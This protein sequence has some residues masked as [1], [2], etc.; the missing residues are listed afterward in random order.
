MRYS[1]VNQLSFLPDRGRAVG[2]LD[3]QTSPHEE[4][5]QVKV[6]EEGRHEEARWMSL[7]AS[8][9]TSGKGFGHEDLSA[10][11]DP[12]CYNSM[13][14]SSHAAPRGHLSE[15]DDMDVYDQ[16]VDS[17]SLQAQN[18][19]RSNLRTFS[20][21]QRKNKVMVE[22]SGASSS[23]TPVFNP[24]VSGEVEVVGQN[25]NNRRFSDYAPKNEYENCP[26]PLEGGVDDD[27]ETVKTLDRGKRLSSRRTTKEAVEFDP[28][29][30]QR[31]FRMTSMKR[32]RGMEG[33]GGGME[34]MPD[35]SLAPVGGEGREEGEEVVAKTMNVVRERQEVAAGLSYAMV[36]MSDKRKNRVEVDQM[37]CEGS[38]LPQHYIVQPILSS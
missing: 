30:K 27:R 7:P 33:S 9:Y 35:S 38:G 18:S 17:L 28:N 1:S 13:E 25:R 16:P 10:I 12:G 34:S 37:K 26:K 31:I 6:Q 36:N 24:H 11:G 3:G 32:H 4:V 8:T 29:N 5:E 20:E 2:E 23:Y 19:V 15:P 14:L 22:P 21:G